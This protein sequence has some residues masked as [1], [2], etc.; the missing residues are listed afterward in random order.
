[1]WTI[2]ERCGKLITYDGIYTFFCIDEDSECLYYP[3]FM[4]SCYTFGLHLNTFRPFGGKIGKTEYIFRIIEKGDY[5]YD[6]Y[7][8]EF[9]KAVFV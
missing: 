6:A 3:H 2:S 1:M 5:R 8:E 7:I 4:E 9:R